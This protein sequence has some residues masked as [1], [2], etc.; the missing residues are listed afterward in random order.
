MRSRTH[1]ARLLLAR[2][3]A[4]RRQRCW[5]I[6]AAAIRAIGP[7]LLAGREAVPRLF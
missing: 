2:Q 1:Q 7:G 3:A 6:K 4:A 5:S